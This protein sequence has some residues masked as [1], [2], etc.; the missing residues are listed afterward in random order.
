MKVHM[1]QM[2]YVCF[3][4]NGLIDDIVVGNHLL[5]GGE[6]QILET[7]LSLLKVDVAETTV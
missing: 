5:L 3:L 7:S 6:G 4:P 1:Y 2:T